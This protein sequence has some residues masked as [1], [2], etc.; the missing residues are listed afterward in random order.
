MVALG[1]VRDIKNNKMNKF[2]K[3]FEFEF[4]SNNLILNS[5]KALKEKDER[6]VLLFSHLLSSHRMWLCRVN[7]IE[8]TCTLFQER[9][10]AEC[11]NLMAEN[12]NDWKLFLENKSTE[13][14]EQTIEFMSA[15][16]INPSKRKMTIEDAIIHLI[17]HSSYH[18]GQIVASI[19]GKVDELPLSTYI[20]YASEIIE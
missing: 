13:N 2:I 3:Q 5:L 14:L 4:W 19:K 1:M 9:T 20:M 16:E 8:M 7:K 11:E 17:N 12:L 15:W 6:A 10:L 18:R